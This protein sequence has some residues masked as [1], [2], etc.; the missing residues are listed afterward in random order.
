MGHSSNALGIA[1]QK[2]QD[3]YCIDGDGSII[4]HMGSL[5]INGISGVKN[6]K[7]IVLNNGSHESVG[8]QPTV[9]KKIDLALIAKSCGYA[10]TRKVTKLE[11]LDSSIEWIR[12]NEGPLFLEIFIQNGSRSELG[13]PKESPVQNKLLFMKQLDDE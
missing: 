9:G 4:M 1:M 11:E 13:R 6:F 10:S 8:G 3:V 2:E 12:R 7:H 5:A